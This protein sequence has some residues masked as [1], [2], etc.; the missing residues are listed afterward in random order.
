MLSD[1]RKQLLDLIK[2]KGA[3]SI[4]EAVAS[5]DLAKTTLRE[6]FLQ[7]ER[8]GYVQRGY[9]RSGP[10]RPSIIYTLTNKGL[11]VYPSYEGR[12]MKEML[13]Y[14]KDEGKHVTIEAFF[15]AFW[16]E[17]FNNAKE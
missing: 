12:M 15:E 5:T 6:H 4:S 3:L 10:G 9:V 2:H 13:R 1:S 11:N 16:E 14:L 17:R 7:L 8:D